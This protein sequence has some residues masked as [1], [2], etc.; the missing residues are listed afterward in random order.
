ELMKDGDVD[1][2][3]KENKLLYYQ[4]SI[5]ANHIDKV[6]IVDLNKLLKIESNQ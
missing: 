3:E 4:K 5:E 1:N 2:K 6:L